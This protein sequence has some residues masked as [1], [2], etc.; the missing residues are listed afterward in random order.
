MEIHI[1]FTLAV[2][3]AVGRSLFSA[4]AARSMK[5]L[6]ERDA[7]VLLT[8][9]VSIIIAV[10]NAQKTLPLLLGCLEEQTYPKERMYIIIVD[11]R[12]TPTLDEKTLQT[13]FPSLHISIVRIDAVRGNTS[14]KKFAL[15]DAITRSTTEMLLLTDADCRPE[16]HWVE[17]M[18]SFLTNNDVVIGIAPLEKR[19]D[20][21]ARY[22]HYE[23]ARTAILY[24]AAAGWNHPYM[25][26]GRN[27]GFRKSL[28]VKSGGLEPLYNILGGDDDLLL[29]RFVNEGARVS[30]CREIGSYCYS[31]SPASF[32][33]LVRQKLRHYSVSHFYPVRVKLVLGLLSL[34]D[35]ITLLGLPVAASL[36][37][38]PVLVAL[39]F[40][41]GK[42][43]YDSKFVFQF[44][45]VQ[46]KD[47]CVWIHS[48]T[49]TC[50]FAF[51]EIFH[52]VFST[53]IG[54]ATFFTKPRW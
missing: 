30:V 16:P 41:I 47:S 53:V 1:V 4:L 13:F 48:L 11:D 35:W 14:P 42:L 18:T 21:V 26:V 25:A 6:P 43:M 19:R 10:H 2:F 51:L 3:A 9:E 44:S 50:S 54:L 33:H 28:Y 40:I 5:R 8:D 32:S 17:N 22:A 31:D 27:W 20:V 39:L 24:C 23:S 46:K 29:Q 38:I 15:N 34:L 12:S 36:S 45:A 37:G 7:A 49:A 52:I